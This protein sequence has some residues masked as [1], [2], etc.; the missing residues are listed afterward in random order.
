MEKTFVF[1]VY[2]QQ[3]NKNN[4]QPSALEQ[5]NVISMSLQGYELGCI[6]FYPLISAKLLQ[7]DQR[8]AGHS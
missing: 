6:L 2:F 3:K 5:Y 7:E 1:S 4:N 8:E